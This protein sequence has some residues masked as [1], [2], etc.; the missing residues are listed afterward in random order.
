MGAYTVAILNTRLQLPV[1]W[2][3]PVAGLVAALF[4]GVV[5]R[6]VLHLRGDYLLI[7]TIGLGEIVRIALVTNVFGLTG[8]ANGIYGIARPVLFGY[9]LRGS[10]HPQDFFYFIWAFVGLTIFLLHRLERSRFGRALTYLREDEVAAEGCGIDTVRYKLLAFV[11]GAA[12][13]GVTGGIY[14]AK[15]TVISPESFNFW[16]SV[17]LFMIVILG[18]SGSI[19]GMLVGATLVVAVP[20][21]ARD[22]ASWR[23]LVFGFVM[24]VMMIFRP[25]GILPW[26]RV[27]FREQDLVGL[28]V[29]P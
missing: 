6:P 29:R 10:L 19:P 4:A 5:A 22:L 18:G 27:R 14:A 8:G 9:R 15:M 17:V 12:W 1:M 7:V 24:V 20:E 2:A 28:G 23:M 13:A 25:Q 16:E 11:V 21:L 3:L 26:R